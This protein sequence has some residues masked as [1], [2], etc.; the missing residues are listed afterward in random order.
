MSDDRDFEALLRRTLDRKGAP[1]PFSID[2]ADRVMARVAAIGAP[3]RTEMNLRQFGRWAVAASVVGAALAAA[4]FWQ[5]PSLASVYAGV[6]HTLADAAGAAGK[7]ATPAGSIAGAL[8]RVVFAL[9]SSAKTLVQP[10]EPLQPLAHA[11]LAA[12]AAVMLSITTFI[13]GRDLGGRVADK[14]RA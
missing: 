10:L 7:L 9:A 1:A 13:V 2:V 4:A 11:M 14:E 12:V 5:G 8:G 3:R 6:L